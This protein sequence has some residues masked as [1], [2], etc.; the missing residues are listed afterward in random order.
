LP[1]VDLLYNFV[2]TSEF[3]DAVAIYEDLVD[4]S[5]PRDTLSQEFPMYD[6]DGV[7]E[8]ATTDPYS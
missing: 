2:I 5:Q 4:D 8:V 1:D 3:P 7:D 6:D